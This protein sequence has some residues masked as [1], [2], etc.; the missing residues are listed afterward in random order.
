MIG[1]CTI[2]NCNETQINAASLGGFFAKF[3]DSSTTTITNQ[4]TLIVFPFNARENGLFPL[5]ISV[6]GPMHWWGNLQFRQSYTSSRNG[7][8]G[9]LAVEW[10]ESRRAASSRLRPS[11]HPFLSPFRICRHLS[12]RLRGPICGDIG[13]I[14]QFSPYIQH[15]VI[16][17]LL[18]C[19]L[20]CM[21]LSDI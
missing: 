10:G 19:W 12:P 11:F 5:S 14:F 16:Q 9:F 13:R 21:L 15:Q 7:V 17:F 18:V 4:K 1:H 6:V 20:L 2:A 8:N 3:S